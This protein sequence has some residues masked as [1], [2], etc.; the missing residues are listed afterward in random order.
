MLGSDIVQ[1]DKNFDDFSGKKSTKLLPGDK[2]SHKNR[3]LYSYKSALKPK[4]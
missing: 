4:A 1:C 3:R 2:A